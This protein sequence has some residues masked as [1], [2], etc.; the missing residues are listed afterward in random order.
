MC[1]RWSHFIWLQLFENSS[2]KTRTNLQLFGLYLLYSNLWTL[3]WISLKNLRRSVPFWRA[4]VQSAQCLASP[5]GPP[6]KRWGHFLSP[7]WSWDKTASGPLSTDW[8]S[9]CLLGQLGFFPF[10]SFSFF[11]NSYLISGQNKD[12]GMVYPLRPAQHG[13]REKS[14]REP[15]VQH[16]WIWD[17]KAQG[18]VSNIRQTLHP[19]LRTVI[20]ITS[21]QNDSNRI[22]SKFSGGTIPGLR[23][24][25][26]PNPLLLERDTVRAENATTHCNNA[27]SS[28]ICAGLQSR[29]TTNQ[30]PI[31]WIK[32]CIC[33][34]DLNNQ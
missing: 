6:R 9:M 20:I 23:L 7:E 18:S 14:W 32:C 2:H 24:A 12:R 33:Y 25:P 8:V 28:N 22:R 5:S 1:W 29:Q 17:R 19:R 3:T 13:E 27:L 21:S 34:N 16:V 26:A 10:P 4:A 31:A 11:F 30:R 15:R